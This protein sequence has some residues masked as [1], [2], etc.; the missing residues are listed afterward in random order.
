MKVKLIYKYYEI[1]MIKLKTMENTLSILLIK[2][3]PIL[4]DS[5][6]KFLMNNTVS[7]WGVN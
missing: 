3:F 4:F 2:I 5:F 6:N 1:K 7:R